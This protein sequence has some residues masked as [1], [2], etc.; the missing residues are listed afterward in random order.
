MQIVLTDVLAVIVVLGTLVLVHEWGHYAVA[1][2]CGVRVEVFSLGFG[3][4]LWGFKRGDTDYRLSA[5]PFGGY[6][7]MSGENPMEEHTGAPWEFMSHPR[8][9]RFLIAI[10]GPFMNVLLCVVVL[11]GVNMVHYEDPV[12]LSQPTVIGWVEPGSIAAKAGLQ[13]GDRVVQIEDANDPTWETTYEKFTIGAGTLTHL[14][15]QRDGKIVPIQVQ[16]NN[17]DHLGVLPDQPYVVTR[18]EPGLP[19]AKAGLQLGDEVL[20][21]DGAT[22]RSTPA[23]SNYLQTVKDRPVDIKLKRNGKVL[24]FTVT[25]QLTDVGGDKR[26]RVGIVSDPVRIEQLSF[27]AAFVQSLSD[28]KKNSLLILDLL[29]RLAHSGKAIKQMSSIIGIGQVSGEAAREGLL[30]FL[31]ILAVISLNLGIFNLLPIPILDGGLI[32][33]LIIE[34]L[35]RR[36]IKREVKELVYQAAFVF[37]IIFAAIVIF[38]DISKLHLG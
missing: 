10:A 34:G 17:T 24:D 12:F 11:T 33:L 23:L 6:V 36:E 38:N 1:K 22:V 25:P 18:I 31:Y 35:L 7:R 29:R 30:P 8:W 13:A 28:T 14:K 2:L 9:Q 27:P 16:L 20:S 15:A 19:A 5:L 3:K 37:L 4:R 26:Y 21:V 32:L